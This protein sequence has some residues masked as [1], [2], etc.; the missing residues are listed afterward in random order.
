MNSYTMTGLDRLQQTPSLSKS[1]GRCALLCNQASLALNSAHSTEVFQRLPGISLSCLLSPQHGIS[2]TVQDNMIETSHSEH[3]SLNV[4]V[5]SLYSEVREPCPSML[6]TS[7]TLVI[8]L[9]ISGCRIYTFKA[10]ILACLKAAK[11]FRKKVV[12]LDRPNPL[13]GVVL[14]GGLADPLMDSFVNPGKIPMRHGLT[15]AEFALLMNG[16]IGC[17]LEYIALAG[18]DATKTW[19]GTGRNWI[20]T[21]PNLPTADAVCLY[22]GMVLFEGCNVSEGRGTA[23]PFQL[24]GSPFLENPLRLVHFVRELLGEN[25]KGVL[26]RPTSFEPTFGKWRGK[27]CKGLQIHVSNPEEVRSFVLAIALLQ[28]FQE[29][30]GDGFQFRQPPYEYE[31]RRSPMDMILATAQS[32][33]K[34]MSLP[35]EDSFW[36]PDLTDYIDR[37]QD[38]LLYP[39]EMKSPSFHL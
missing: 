24:I 22:P 10:T 35:P 32:H 12:I 2:G 3:S 26:L 1:W 8:D 15:A 6:E 19:S 4:P 25:L 13:G 5:H 37:I 14:E 16:D 36:N 29:L 9:Q 38:S 11:A 7:D 28:G 23:L 34:L 20:L 21:S 18:W 27:E 33:E 31:Y 39:R 17:D 30:C